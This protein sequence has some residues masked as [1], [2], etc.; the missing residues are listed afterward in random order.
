MQGIAIARSPRLAAAGTRL[1]FWIAPLATLA[2]F[3]A[4]GLLERNDLVRLLWLMVILAIASAIGWALSRSLRIA[5]ANALALTWMGALAWF[6][7]G[8]PVLATLLLLAGSLALGSLIVRPGTMIG[9]LM[10]LVVG[11]GLLSATAG[12][13]LPFPI[14]VRATYLG[15]LLL[16]VVV[17]WRVLVDVLRRV[18]RRF[19]RATAATPVTACL[20]IA[21][22]GLASTS[23]WVPT[24]Q[25]DDLAYHLGLPFELQTLGYYRMDAA[26]SFW[27][28]APWTSDV[29]HGLVQVMAGH[30]ARGAVTTMWLTIAMAAA[31]QLGRRLRVSIALRWW[32]VAAIAVS[33]LVAGQ[34][35]GMQTEL[36]TMAGVLVL[37]VAL[38]V[39]APMRT[40]RLCV[41]AV[42]AGMLLGIKVS[43]IVLLAPMA[44]WALVQF[45]R[46]PS[47]PGLVGATAL[48]VVAGGSSYVY[49]WWLAK[50]PVLPL[51]NAVFQSPYYPLKNFKDGR[52]HAGVDGWMPW[53]LMFD[54]GRFGELPPG[55]AG[56][57]VLVSLVGALV[58]LRSPRTRPIA[59]VGLCATMLLFTQIQYARYAMPAMAV[60]LVAAVGAVRGVR[61]ARD[62]QIAMGLLLALNLA[63]LPFAHHRL[64]GGLL[65]T[66]IQKGATAAGELYIPMRAVSRYLRESRPFG[67]G[68]W[69]YATYY[70]AE[71]AGQLRTIGPADRATLQAAQNDASGAAWRRFL[72]DSGVRTIVVDAP[73]RNDGMS[74][75][76]AD[77][78][79]VREALID[80]FEV[81][82][83]PGGAQLPLAIPPE[84][85]PHR[86]AVKFA[87]DR[88]REVDVVLAFTCDTPGGLIFVNLIDV[89]ADLKKH[90]LAAL[91]TFCGSDGRAVLQATVQ[92][93]G[94]RSLLVEARP[95][96]VTFDLVQY[97]VYPTTAAGGERDLAMQVRQRVAGW[98]GLS[99]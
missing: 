82:R 97:D 11:L 35:S 78:G 15:V 3:L 46:F 75:A 8:G 43:N 72:A 18:A 71:N 80:V 90:E 48:G 33:P 36:P 65:Q 23:A 68:V 26:G 38:F 66:T 32:L 21:L 87:P 41:V 84:K 1:L 47:L 73:H 7:G 30:E 54:S 92:R 59:F 89:D 14:H 12:W 27:A 6:V 10:A 24:I 52:W 67:P 63:V 77:V 60:M 28:L 25:G 19:A 16:L 88:L 93:A 99:G 70:P 64:R 34:L 17:R 4:H 56:M 39:P 44:L 37:A 13:L 45:R 9:T 50:N 69:A 94:G 55:G 51:F 86:I 2:G 42:L 62:V 20:A 74:R 83:I 96:G 40:W 79:A 61:P 98:L 49:A 85:K 31:W 5:F 57:L 76:L 81:W 22:I 53:D 58:A 91:R 29:V 95:R